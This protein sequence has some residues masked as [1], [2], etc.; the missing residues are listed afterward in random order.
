M[1]QGTSKK[2]EQKDCKSQCAKRSAVKESLLDV[3]TGISVDISMWRE[4]LLGLT[5]RHLELLE[6]GELPSP[7]DEP[8]DWLYNAK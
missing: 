6:E 7:K 2:R 1:T 3:A 8:L 5:L 4:G